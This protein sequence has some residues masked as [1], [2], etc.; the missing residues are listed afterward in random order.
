M[1]HNIEQRKYINIDNP[2]VWAMTVVV[3]Y[4]QESLA[5]WE[6]S[7]KLSVY[8]ESISTLKHG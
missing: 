4:S 7:N 2:Q 8:I 3:R 6:Y 5:I 1:S